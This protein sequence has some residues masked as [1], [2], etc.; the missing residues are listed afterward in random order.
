M[1]LNNQIELP[2]DQARAWEALN[3]LETL[4]AS[5]PGCESLEQSD[6]H[7]YELTI[8]ATI[9]PVRARFKGRLALSNLV[10]PQSY[11]ID[12]EGQGGVAGH[13][14][15]RATVHLESTGPATTT[16]H[17]SAEASVGGKIA[18]IGQ[19]LVDMAAQRMANEFFGNF[20]KQLEPPQEPN[21]QAP[22][23]DSLWSRWGQKIARVS[24]GSNSAGRSIE[25]EKG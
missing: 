1:K 11:E 7:K 14:K 24:P 25:S 21:D 10:P 13:G 6:E 9:G 2:V 20:T 17:Y 22:M 19:R 15:G 3:D 4:K 12:F 8:L 5:I 23:K 18:Q 16:L